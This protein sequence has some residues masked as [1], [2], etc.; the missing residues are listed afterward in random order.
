[1]NS[2]NKQN[3]KSF[4]YWIRALIAGAVLLAGAAPV[5]ADVLP[6]DGSNYAQF[7]GRWWKSFMQLPLTNSAG[8]VHPAID[9]G[10]AAFDVTEGQS[11]DIWFL[12]APFGTVT[13]SATIPSG[14]PVF[15]AL[16][17]AEQSS[18]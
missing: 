7:A 10:P 17:T 6:P 5:F 13:R 8:I 14:K 15:F 2:S 9:A 11:S 12:A 18:L 3:A 1:M 4:K 16:L